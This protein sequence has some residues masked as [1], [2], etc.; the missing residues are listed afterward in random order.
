MSGQNLLSFCTGSG[1]SSKGHVH[2]SHQMLVERLPT[3]PLRQVMQA[4]SL[5][6]LQTPCLLEL[7]APYFLEQVPFPPRPPSHLRLVET[8]GHRVEMVSSRY[9][10]YRRL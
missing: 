4:P 2:L 6:E 3:S 5:L 9:C 7:Q 8:S 1:F 10:H